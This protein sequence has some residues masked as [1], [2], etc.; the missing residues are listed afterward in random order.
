MT[1]FFVAAL[2]GVCAFID[3]Q[4][5]CF[6][7]VVQ[8]LFDALFAGLIVRIYVECFIDRVSGLDGRLDAV[9]W[10]VGGHSGYGCS[11]VTG[12]LFGYPIECV[13][14]GSFCDRADCLAR[15]RYDRY[16]FEPLVDRCAWWRQVA[17]G[18]SNAEIKS[19]VFDPGFDAFVFAHAY[20]DAVEA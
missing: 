9:R 18:V 14:P 15:W 6:D 3:D 1:T 19:V 10:R 7:P 13:W 8:H 2:P 12:V 16:L 11:H 5:V 20:Q 4:H 17:F